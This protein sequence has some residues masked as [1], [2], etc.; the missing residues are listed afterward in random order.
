MKARRLVAAMVV[1]LQG[2]AA[3]A[4]P[5]LPVFH[6]H[7]AQGGGQDF[8]VSLQ[9]FVLLTALSFLPSIIVLTTSFT[10]I[11]VVLAM[12]R[13]GLGTVQTPSNMILIGLALFLTAFTMRPVFE[14]S[15]RDGIAPYLNES[16]TLRAALP[17]AGEPWRRFMLNQARVRDVQLF[18]R[19]AQQDLAQDS[20]SLANKAPIPYTTLV[21]AFATSELTTAFQMGFVVLL[22]FLII[23]LVVASVLMTMGMMMMSPM[24]VSFPFKI[25]L[26]VLVDGWPLLMA[27]L[28]GSFH[29]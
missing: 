28:F 24:L 25:M 19:L 21:P 11:I 12:L 26:F 15:Y 29:I 13:Q 17:R 6:S 5:E 22:P 14:A 18:A 2:S 4:A 7:P 8:T 23:D 16:M 3:L 27:A 10:R 20:K 9:I 1:M